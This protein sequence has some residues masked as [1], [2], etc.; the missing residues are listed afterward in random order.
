MVIV[1][2]PLRISFAGGGSDI[3]Q[4][5]LEHGGATLSTAINKYVYVTVSKHFH[6]DQLRVSYSKTENVSH[7]DELE[8]TRVREALRHL[9]ISS[10]LEIVTLADIPSK[11]T[12]LGS[13]SSFL[14]GLLRALYAHRG[15]TVSEQ[16]LADEACRIEI[17]VLKEPIG[18]QDQYIASFGGFKFI[19]Y[20]SSGHIQVDCVLTREETLRDLEDSLLLFYT[21]IQRTAHHVLRE[22]VQGFSEEKNIQTLKEMAGMAKTLKH[23][24]ENGKLEDF[25]RVLHEGWLLKRSL[26]KTITNSEI[27]AMYDAARQNG[28]L[29]GKILGAGGGG[30]LMVFAPPDS[31]E[32][33]KKALCKYKEMEIKFDPEGSKVLFINKNL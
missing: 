15:Q 19:Q 2:A 16:Q 7:L 31:H 26:A 24:L 11:G 12:G 10:G 13:S 21:G 8:H 5:Y 25:G 33:I 14:V 27:D 20:L 17:E 18:K 4:F 30:F 22:Q 29:G 9:G 1:K 23:D 6:D 32:G 3:P 28:A